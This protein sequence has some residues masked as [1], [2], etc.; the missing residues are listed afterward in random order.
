M[1]DISVPSPI[2][3]AFP[4]RL[5]YPE[6]GYNKVLIESL[7]EGSP[8]LTWSKKVAQWNSKLNGFCYLKRFTRKSRAIIANVL[9]PF[10]E[11]QKVCQFAAYE[12]TNT[13]HLYTDTT[14]PRTYHYRW[15]HERALGPS[16]LGRFDK[17]GHYSGKEY[18]PR[19]IALAKALGLKWAVKLKPS[20]ATNWRTCHN[21]SA[22]YGRP[23]PTNEPTTLEGLIKDTKYVLAKV[24]NKEK[25]LDA[26][27]KER[28]CSGAHLAIIAGALHIRTLLIFKGNRLDIPVRY[29]SFKG[30]QEH[31]ALVDSGA[32]ETFMD[33]MTVKK[34]KLG[35]KK[36]THPI[37]VRNIDGTNNKAGHI[38]DFI[39]LIITRGTKKVPSRFYV[40]N[41][42][43]DRAI[44][45]YPW[46]RD[47]NPD[48][49]WPTGKLRGPQVEIETPFYS[50]FP[51]MRRIMEKREKHVTPALDHP[52]DDIKVRAAET[53]NPEAPSKEP[54]TTPD[55]S[56]STHQVPAED[57]S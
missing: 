43:G 36:L 17:H 57:L 54:E 6:E 44:L 8:L 22:E 39:E 47:F 38:T 13:Q 14:G 40:T 26:L 51:T 11:G 27:I 45:G 29:H 23:A 4:L 20:D 35:T 15:A 19:Q 32:M 34:L 42:G 2:D 37:P 30:T 21:G 50:R 56:S 18:T 41:L 33:H 24:G 9:G 53:Q 25:Y 48:I 12:H 5:R 31:L 49:D 3:H 52:S 7:Y 1:K 16:Y 10:P 46:L 55:A 28:L